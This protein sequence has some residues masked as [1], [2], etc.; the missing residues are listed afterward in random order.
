MPDLRV[1]GDDKIRDIDQAGCCYLS[2]QTGSPLYGEITR[3]D[4]LIHCES[5]GEPAAL[6][7]LY[8]V[9]DFGRVVLGTLPLQPRNTPHNLSLELA[10]GKLDRIHDRCRAWSELGFTPSRILNE[11][12]SYAEK[13]IKQAEAVEE[14]NPSRCALLAEKA[15]TR[16]TWAGEGIALEAAQHCLNRKIG[17]GASGRILLGCNLGRLELGQEL[18]PIEEVFNYATV[19]FGWRDFEPTAGNEQWERLDESLAWLRSHG[20]KANGHP[21][22]WFSEEAYPAWA[23]RNTFE[24]LKSVNVERVR[25]V[26]SRGRGT[27]QFWNVVHEA[28]DVDHANIFGLGRARLAELTTSA[29]QAAREADPAAKLAVTVCAPFG[30]YAATRSG[31]WTPLDYLAAC[32]KNGADFDIVAVQFA[33]GGPGHCRDL[34]EISAQLDRYG[35]LGKPV[36][37]TQ[38]GC[39]SSSRPHPIHRAGGL[40][41]EQ[42]GEWHA[43]WSESLQAEWVEKFYTICCGKPYVD[44]VNWWDLADYNHRYLAHGGLLRTDHTPKPAYHRLKEFARTMNDER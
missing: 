2:G 12:V 24:E 26:V 14:Y 25:R 38:V 15:L 18:G 8:R 44:A 39:P 30:E 13:L 7:V 5:F 29:T 1:F 16:A 11:E 21:L 9:E 36:H 10:R 19:P 27:V 33:C 40:T 17:G 37:V 31:R 23:R 28:H 41:P 35:A 22:I 4:N 6:H 43:P 32:M 3:A 42:A 34:L 20:M